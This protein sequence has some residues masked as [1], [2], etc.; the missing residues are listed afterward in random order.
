MKPVLVVGLTG[1]SL[2]LPMEE[3]RERFNGLGFEVVFLR[4]VVGMVVVYPD[5]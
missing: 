1:E 5:H 3:I 4:G 2:S